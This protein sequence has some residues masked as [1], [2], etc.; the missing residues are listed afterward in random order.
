MDWGE[1]KPVALKIWWGLRK[2]CV[3]NINTTRYVCL[4][5][6]V[7]DRF[8]PLFEVL[9]SILAIT[10]YQGLDEGEGKEEREQWKEGK[11][12]LRVEVADL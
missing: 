11:G 2:G 1:K 6:H 8:Q 9:H 3:L 12:K 10:S 4:C 5:V 7:W